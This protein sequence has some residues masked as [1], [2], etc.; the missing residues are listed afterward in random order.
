MIDLKRFRKDK[1]LKQKDI[2]RTT[3]L[4]QS[5]ISKYES[6]KQPTAHVE[7]VL[8]NNYPEL[9]SYMIQGKKYKEASEE[10][11]IAADPEIPYR[12]TD[13]NERV[14]SAQERVISAQERTISLLEE[15]V[16]VLKEEYSQSKEEVD[17]LTE[18]V[19]R[20]SRPDRPSGRDSGHGEGDQ[21]K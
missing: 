13:P 5:V 7:S 9:E 6:G 14:I 20:L 11:S 10:T 16:G 8:L 19:R 18:E 12:K 1:K 3:G 2:S 15:K 17:R 21:S 4:D